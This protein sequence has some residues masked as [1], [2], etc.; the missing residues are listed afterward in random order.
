MRAK[1]RETP[2]RGP[3]MTYRIRQDTQ[4]ERKV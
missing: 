1:N 3:A 2:R 4:N